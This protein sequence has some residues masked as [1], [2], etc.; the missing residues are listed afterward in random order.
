MMRRKGILIFF[1]IMIF[2]LLA[3]TA[4]R[5][6]DRSTW[7]MEVAP[8]LI[9]GPVL[10]L[11]YRRFPLTTLLYMLLLLHGIVLITGGAYT[12]TRGPFRVLA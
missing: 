9:A 10:V 8:V 1:L 2:A 3:V 12:H 7:L 6:Y 4:V 5:P 11:T